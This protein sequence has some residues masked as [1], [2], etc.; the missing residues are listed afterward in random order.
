MAPSSSVVGAITTN[1]SFSRH[2]FIWSR[3]VL[4][5][6]TKGSTHAHAPAR[7]SLLPFI[8]PSMRGAAH[9]PPARLPARARLPDGRVQ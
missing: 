8:H 6:R 3:C 9:G 2:S 4:F 7:A 5:P 1:G